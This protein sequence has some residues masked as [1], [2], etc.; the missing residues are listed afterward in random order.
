MADTKQ[1]SQKSISESKLSLLAI[2]GAKTKLA[3]A[4]NKKNRLEDNSINYVQYYSSDNVNQ[5][6]NQNQNPAKGIPKI[7]KHF[8]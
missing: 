7:Q 1:E 3:I 6:Q 8:M 5:N 4:N 2:V